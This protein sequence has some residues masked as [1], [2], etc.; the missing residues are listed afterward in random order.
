MPPTISTLN[1]SM[2]TRCL[3]GLAC[4][5]AGCGKSDLP[6]L[7]RVAGTVT[8][9]GVPLPAALVVYTPEGPGRSAMATTDTAGRYELAYLRDIEGANVGNH[10]VRI[11]T[12]GDARGAKEMLPPRYHRKTELSA[13]VEAGSNTLDFSLESK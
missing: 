8:L 12:A 1:P 13:V 6:P 2:F 11:T 10:T 3:I 9:D 7:G 5:A 4:L